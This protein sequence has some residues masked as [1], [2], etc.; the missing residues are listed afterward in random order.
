MTRQAKALKGTIEGE[1]SRA[2]ALDEAGAAWGI[3]GIIFFAVLREGFETVVFIAAQFQRGWLPSLGA[4]LGLVGATGIGALLFKWGVRINLQRFFQVMG[5]ALLLIIGGLA[6]GMLAHLDQGVTRLTQLDDRWLP[7]CLMPSGDG[8]LLGRQ[9]W[10][11]SLTL[12]D[13]QFPG[14]LL[15]TLLG[16]RDQLYLVEL[17]SYV[18]LLAIVGGS[19]FR[20]L[21]LRSLKLPPNA[22]ELARSGSSR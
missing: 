3:F 18:G 16:Y 11:L 21:N 9:I 20:S 1:L 10:D 19:Y 17:I 4:L 2:I 14:L 22:E 6:V 15:K 12:P 13:R 8:C 7:L 5:L